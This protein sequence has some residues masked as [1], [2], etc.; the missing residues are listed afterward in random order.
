VIKRISGSRK[1]EVKRTKVK[2]H[3][4][5]LQVFLR[6]RR[7]SEDGIHGTVN[8][9]WKFIFVFTVLVENLMIR[10]ACM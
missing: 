5:G 2:L 10:V 7:Y 1:E 8:K 4:V 9:Y 3:N 6:F